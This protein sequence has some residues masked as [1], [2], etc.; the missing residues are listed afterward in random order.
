MIEVQDDGHGMTEATRARIFD[1][2]FTT[3]FTGRGLG[4][5]AALG[6]VRGHRGGITVDSA[7]GAGTTF[8][9]F[10][11]VS[12]SAEP[13]EEKNDVSTSVCGRGTILIVDDESIVRNIAKKALERYGYEVLAAE[14]GEAAL[15]IFKAAPGSVSLVLLDM[16][17]PGM[18]GAE[19]L[20][21]LR[22]IRPSVCVIASSGYSE[23]DAMERFG[24]G[25]AGFLQKPW[26]AR[27]LAAKVSEVLQTA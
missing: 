9:I 11:P 19:T 6:I 4:L 10:L 3:K 14:D 7:P 5:A 13:P 8:R 2:F 22:A 17:M 23:G 15:E 12:Q 20:K 18:G 24:E 26:G 27:Q 25:L 1:P 21:N 16:A